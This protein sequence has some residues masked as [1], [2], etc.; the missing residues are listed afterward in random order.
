[1]SK[2]S[3]AS[4]VISSPSAHENY[5]E[6]IESNLK[7]LAKSYNSTTI[8]SF[9]DHVKIV[10]EKS[11]LL[12]GSNEKDKDE[13]IGR[14][15]YERVSALIE[16][17]GDEFSQMILNH[18]NI[19]KFSQACVF[20]RSKI[21]KDIEDL[22]D[23]IDVMIIVPE[24]EMF[25]SKARREIKNRIKELEPLYQEAL[26]AARDR[27]DREIIKASH[28]ADMDEI[29]SDMTDKYEDLFQV[30]HDEYR[31]LVRNKNDAVSK[32]RQLK[33]KQEQATILDV[34]LKAYDDAT[35]QIVTKVKS[36]LSKFPTIASALKG[37]ATVRSTR[38]EIPN[39]FE[40]ENL[41]GI[42][43]ILFDRYQKKSFV[44][45]TNA[46]IDAMNWKLSEEDTLKNPSKGVSEVQQLYATWERKDLWVQLTKDLFFSV[47]LMKGLHP[48]VSFRR[49]VLTE[50]T[51]YIQH[52]NTVDDEFSPLRDPNVMPVFKFLC[53]YITREQDNR[54][55][56]TDEDAN[57]SSQ[58]AKKKNEGN[59]Q[60]PWQKKGTIVEAAAAAAAK[61][62][63][64]TAATTESNG[65]L[66]SGE[67]LKSANITVRDNVKNKD[68]TYLAV[69]K[70]SK[71]CPKC[72]PDDGNVTNPCERKCYQSRCIKCQYFGHKYATCLQSH[73]VTGEK[74]DR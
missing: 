73:K 49:E 39:P 69:D 17:V 61:D 72:Y 43:E 2:M 40:N 24:K 23:D 66:F 58:H 28:K 42:V 12:A 15:L 29:K 34:I 20:D 74:I 60:Q 38:E 52:L 35:R 57:K 4:S 62:S 10:I 32:T 5:T 51:K 8:K 50:T 31:K 21:N 65:K 56:M 19:K 3:S 41:T 36:A 13:E 1:M 47:I 11:M 22:A 53:D 64:S 46:L 26:G 67:V 30:E 9:S 44:S 68:F 45:F 63:T 37:T 71:I 7:V 16:S 54:K 70:L 48:S 55:M 33:I 6:E 27:D 14:K 18:F 25:N 59:Q